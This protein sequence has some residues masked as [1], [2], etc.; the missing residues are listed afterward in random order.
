[1]SLCYVSSR[2]KTCEKLFRKKDKIGVSCCPE[3]RRSWLGF[4]MNMPSQFYRNAPQVLGSQPK[5]QGLPA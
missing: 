3:G 1:M 5:T 2:Y 4:T